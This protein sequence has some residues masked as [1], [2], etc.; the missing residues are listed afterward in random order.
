M[1]KE[2]HN[3]IVAEKFAAELYANTGIDLANSSRTQ[4]YSMY[5]QAFIHLC[6]TQLGIRNTDVA[7]II[8][9]DHSSVVHSLKKAYTLLDYDDKLFIDYYER[10]KD[11]LNSVRYG[12]DSYTTTM[13]HSMNI[14]D[15]IRSY[16]IEHKIEGARL[17]QVL[18]Q[19]THNIKINRYA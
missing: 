19:L 4:V 9:R 16:L 12:D 5:R 8:N 13:G 2:I 7:G 11:A 14:N 3:L 10:A 17:N 18:Q 15:L 6:S 1:K